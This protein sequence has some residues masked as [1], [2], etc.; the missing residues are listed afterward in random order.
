[1]CKSTV[2]Q[3]NLKMHIFLYVL[4]DCQQNAAFHKQNGSE[5]QSS[6][7][8]HAQEIVLHV[9]KMR[10]EQEGIILGCEA[11]VYAIISVTIQSPVVRRRYVYIL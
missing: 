8:V 1:M 10:H 6:G 4:A 2:S 3:L 9:Q 5:S 11:F 7:C